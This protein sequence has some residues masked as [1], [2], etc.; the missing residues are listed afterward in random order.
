MMILREP[1]L[2]FIKTKKTGGSSIEITL[3]QLLRAGDF[4]SPLT[5]EEESLR[6]G[7]RKI[8]LNSV[9][10]LRE[11][12]GGKI[13]VRNP[14]AGIEIVN[15]YLSDLADG[16]TRFCV[17][18]NPWDKAVSAFY[19]W[20]HQRKTEITN[21]TEQFARF[22]RA[23]LRYFSD[24]HL[25]SEE[26]QIAVDRV[27]QYD[28]LQEE[29]DSFLKSLGIG[30]VSLSGVRAKSGIRQSSR[31]EQFYGEDWSFNTVERVADVFR[32][33]ID[34]FGYQIPKS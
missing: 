29:F 4:A 28:N 32:K 5:R 1:K 14:H 20:M 16:C 21:P 15:G 17:E 19:F 9:K 33:E 30:G 26:G 18:R 24:F 23:Q 11:R 8:V 25:Y 10:M 13:R 27:L 12:G 34:V 3:G 2:V 22:C 31:F 7:K 6:R